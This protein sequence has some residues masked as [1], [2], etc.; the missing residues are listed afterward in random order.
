MN[1]VVITTESAERA[2]A[3]RS[4]LELEYGREFRIKPTERFTDKRSD[5]FD[6]FC[7]GTVNTDAFL[8]MVTFATGFVA[9]LSKGSN[10][11]YSWWVGEYK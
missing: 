11:F 10:R 7:P 1:Q 5:E 6:V 3:V 4:A 2:E 9:G 8:S